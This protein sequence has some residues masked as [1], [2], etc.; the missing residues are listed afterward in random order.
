MY[1]GACIRDISLVAGLRQRGH[2]VDLIALYTPLK[3][4]VDG[5]AETASIYYG[6]INVFLQQASAL[7]RHT[8]ARFY[9]LLDSSSLLGIA[10]HFGVQTAP[11][12]LGPMTVSVLAGKDGRQRKEL[13]RL[14]SRFGRVGSPDVSNITNSLLSGIAPEL[15]AATGAAVVCNVQGEDAFLERIPEPHYSE[16]MRL[17]RV[18][19]KSVDLFLAPNEMHARKMTEGLGIPSTKMVVV[20]AGVDPKPLARSTERSRKPFTIGY[21]SVINPTKGLD[22]LVDAFGILV[23]GMKRD[24]RLHV[25]GRVLD[26]TFWKS[27]ARKLSAQGLES[28]AVFDGELE[29]EGKVEFLHGVSAFCVP[30]RIEESR[31]MVVMEAMAAGLPVVAPESGIFPELI[32]SK[33]HGLMFE[34]GCAESVAEQLA[35]LMDNPDEADA[36]GAAAARRIAERNSLEEMVAGV[37]AAYSRAISS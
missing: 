26:K 5:V 3:G 35:Y 17:L 27:V 22:V 34:P 28:R 13:R 15:R 7:F 25:A 36:I 20:P 18:N 30:S 9:R 29:L 37:E 33:E 8:P 21:L 23:N 19:A 11:E 4:D 12:K 2:E 16:C 1:C 32:G 14:T 24:A 6:G 31:G 10:S